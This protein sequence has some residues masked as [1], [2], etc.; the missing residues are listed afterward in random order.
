MP[1]VVSLLL[2]PLPPPPL[3]LLRRVPGMGLTLYL[4]H[5]HQVNGLGEKKWP[6]KGMVRVVSC[7]RRRRVVVVVVVMAFW[8]VGHHS[9]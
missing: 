6:R 2:L 1:L 4:P 3:L 5:S 7:R 9:T 8:Y